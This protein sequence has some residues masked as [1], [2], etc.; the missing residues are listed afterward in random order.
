MTKIDA[1]MSAGLWPALMT[2]DILS[3]N[4]FNQGKAEDTEFTEST[5]NYKNMSFLIIGL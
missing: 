3:R 5:S 4:C 2:V 1:V